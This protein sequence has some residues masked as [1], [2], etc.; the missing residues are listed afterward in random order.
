MNQYRVTA[1]ALNVRKSPETQGSIVG[2]LP[3]GEQVEKLKVEQKWFYVRCGSLEGWCYSAYLEPATPVAK[4]TLITYKITSDNGGKLEALTRLACNFWNRY[5]LPQQ[6]I[7]IR[8]GVFT[9]F[10]NTIA[11]AWKP[12][13]EQDVVYGTVEFNTNF[14]DMFSDVEIIGTIIHEIGHTL[15]MGWER[16]LTLI[17]TRT[18]RFTP[19]SVARLP[20]LASYRVETDYGPGTTLAHWDEET[21]NRELMTGIKDSQLYVMPM[22]IDVMELLGHKVAER[23]DAKREL[24]DLLAELQSMQFSLYE[25]ADQIDK[26]HY[27]ETEIWEEIYTEKRRPIGR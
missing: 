15:G 14:L 27:V 3:R 24:A 12:Y 9:S 17:D 6:S 2:V 18:G 20:A 7:V 26:N 1:T 23:L 25:V 19:Q 10:G 16:W 8:I 13:T 22:T 5:L 21:Y 11:R 4:T